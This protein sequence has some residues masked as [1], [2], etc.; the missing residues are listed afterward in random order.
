VI[1]GLLD[2]A[3]AKRSLRPVRSARQRRR[4]TDQRLTDRAALLGFSDPQA[5]LAD[6]VAQGAWPL[7]QVAS[8]L[9]I[10]RDTIRDRLDPYGLRRIW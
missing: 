4:M 3:G 10:Y 7:T 6:R 5:Y 9:G 1:R 8:E 2:Q